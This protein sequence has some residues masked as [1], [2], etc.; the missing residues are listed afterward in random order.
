MEGKSEHGIEMIRHIILSGAVK[1]KIIQ[2]IFKNEGENRTIGG[3]V[4][5]TYC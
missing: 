4:I 1:M 3:N 5:V 2:L